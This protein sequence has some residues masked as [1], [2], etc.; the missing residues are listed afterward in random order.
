MTPVDNQS[1]LGNVNNNSLFEIMNSDKAKS[2]RKGMLEGSPL[3][4]SCHRCVSKEKSGMGSMRIGMNDHWFDQ[5]EDLVKNTSA[6]ES[7]SFIG[8]ESG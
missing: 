1:T 5:I 3:P 4:A 2:M 6:S 8:E 7:S